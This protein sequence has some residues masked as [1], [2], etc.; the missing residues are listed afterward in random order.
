MSRESPSD[1]PSDFAAALYSRIHPNSPVAETDNRF[2]DGENVPLIEESLESISAD[3]LQVNQDAATLNDHDHAF[4]GM[5][6][7]ETLAPPSFVSR[8]RLRLENE[9]KRPPSDNMGHEQ[10]DGHMNDFLKRIET[11]IAEQYDRILQNEVVILNDPKYAWCEALQETIPNKSA[12]EFKDAYGIELK[13]YCSISRKIVDD[14]INGY[15]NFFARE[16]QIMEVAKQY[17]DIQQWVHCTQRLFENNDTPVLSNTLQKSLNEQFGLEET[18]R[19]DKDKDLESKIKD[20]KQA[21]VDIQTHRHVV[22][23]LQGIVGHSHY[24]KLCYS[25]QVTTAFVPC[26]HTVCNECVSQLNQCPFCN[27]PFYSTQTLYFS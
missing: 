2:T 26:G 3:T 6:T 10:T 7:K 19:K 18:R 13:E 14:L 5:V 11:D 17:D 22:D 9:L 23:Q 16:K 27:H 25:A 21:W 20:A 8:I 12:Y 15:K 4:S 24:C 1:D